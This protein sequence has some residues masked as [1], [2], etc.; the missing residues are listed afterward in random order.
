M[1]KQ[2]DTLTLAEQRLVNTCSM[3]HSGV[4]GKSTSF[5]NNMFVGIQDCHEVATRHSE[6]NK[7][8]VPFTK[9]AKSSEN[10]RVQ[11]A[12]LYNS[13]PQEVR[14]KQT[15]KAFKQNLKVHLKNSRQP[16]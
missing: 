16:T 10:I 4:T 1:Y 9:L 2:A 7:L 13:V 12:V 6:A 11:G 15:N 8:K 5:M 14:D 3:V